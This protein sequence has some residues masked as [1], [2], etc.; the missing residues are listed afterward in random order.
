M[1]HTEQNMYLKKNID[2]FGRVSDRNNEL[3]SVSVDLSTLNK[4]NFSWPKYHHPKLI[5]LGS[6]IS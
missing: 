3:K 1:K 6:K 5:W 2:N 4:Q